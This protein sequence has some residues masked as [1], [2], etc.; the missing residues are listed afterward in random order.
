VR[1][2]QLLCGAIR[3]FEVWTRR[4]PEVLKSIGISRKCGS[5]K[6]NSDALKPP[7]CSVSLGLTWSHVSVRKLRKNVRLCGTVSLK[8]TC[9]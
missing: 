2:E 3:G 9:A 4:T 5:E 7:S 8:S 6:D 1:C